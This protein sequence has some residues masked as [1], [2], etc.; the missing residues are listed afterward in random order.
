MA[1]LPRFAVFSG[2]TS[3]ISVPN[4]LNRDSNTRWKSLRELQPQILNSFKHSECIFAQKTRLNFCPHHL[5]SHLIT[6]WSGL[7]MANMNRRNKNTASK[8]CFYFLNS[9][10]TVLKILKSF[11]KNIFTLKAKFA[12]S[13]R[14]WSDLNMQTYIHLLSQY[15]CLWKQISRENWC[16]SKNYFNNCVYCK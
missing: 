2:P 11:F 7:L 6:L 8:I 14:S 16:S 15:N 12:R 3:L 9:L 4:V 5:E 10:R 1:V 13:V